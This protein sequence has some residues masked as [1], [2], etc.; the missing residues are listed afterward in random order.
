MSAGRSPRSVVVVGPTASGK[1]ALAMALAELLGDA[2][3]VSVDSM[4]VYRRMDI[5]TATPSAEERERVPHHLLD[6][7]EPSEEGSASWFQGEAIRTLDDLAASGRRAILVGGTGLYH[8][9]VVDRLQIPP[10]FP[11]LRAQLEADLAEADPAEADAPNGLAALH[12]RLAE[13][14]PLAASRTEPSNPRR[15]LRA[16]EVTL[17]SGRPF[18]SFGPGLEEY[19][20]SEH[21]MVGLRPR[22]E[23]LA[24][25]IAERVEAMMRQGWLEEVESLLAEPLPLSRTAAQALGYRELIA[26]LGGACSLEAAVEETVVRTRQFA[27]RQDRWF[28][29]D[30]RIRWYDVEGADPA[31]T[32]SLAAR[33]A[34]TLE[35]T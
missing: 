22:R 13:L 6:L 10:Q 30:P 27:V 4:Q 16:L 34:S 9:A 8:R 24:G 26:H 17:G 15:I 23:A 18:S 20:P 14:D 33:I 11:D 7:L 5:G 28:R 19:P 2:E 32:R 3:L 12:A 35:E 1:S 31:E 29:R 21:L 25:R